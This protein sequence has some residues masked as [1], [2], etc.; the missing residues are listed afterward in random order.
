ML[1]TK[2]IL[3]IKKRWMYKELLL[4]STYRIYKKNFI[5]F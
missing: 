5:G 3:Q 4:S 2:I 1:Y